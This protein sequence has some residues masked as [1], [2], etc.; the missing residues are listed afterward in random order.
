MDTI[1]EDIPMSGIVSI[2]DRDGYA[3]T[4]SCEHVMSMYE[5]VKRHFMFDWTHCA[6]HDK[7]KGTYIDVYG[8]TF[9]NMETIATWWDSYENNQDSLIDMLSSGEQ[10]M[11]PYM[12]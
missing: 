11:P 8:N 12:K 7:D 10:Q 6:G 2:Y 9:E 4:F 3:F 5:S 1:Y